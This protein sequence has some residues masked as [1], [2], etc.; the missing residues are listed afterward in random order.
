M[1]EPPDGWVTYPLPEAARDV[2]LPWSVRCAS[3]DWTEDGFGAMV[4]ASDAL[5]EHRFL[6]HRA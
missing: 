4:E 6:T 5:Y 2:T 3:C 1:T